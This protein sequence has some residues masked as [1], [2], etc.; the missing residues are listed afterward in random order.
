MNE[1]IYI[2]NIKER[3]FND[4]PYDVFIKH[5]EYLYSL[6]LENSTHFWYDIKYLN[7]CLELFFIYFDQIKT[8]LPVFYSLFLCINYQKDKVLSSKINYLLS[9]DEYIFN[10]LNINEEDFYIFKSIITYND[11]VKIYPNLF[12][13]LSLESENGLVFKFKR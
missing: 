12:T 10:D 11:Y 8:P 1:I 6:F 7:S 2:N 9:N 4:L 5:I 3:L 13:G